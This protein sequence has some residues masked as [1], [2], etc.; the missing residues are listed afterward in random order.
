MFAVLTS[1]TSGLKKKGRA[2]SQPLKANDPLTVERAVR[3]QGVEFCFSSSFDM[4]VCLLLLPLAVYSSGSSGGC[5]VRTGWLDERN[6][7]WYYARQALMSFSA[8]N[9]L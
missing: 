8:R 3:E 7:P 9:G 1:A 5:R 2:G 4:F 6:N